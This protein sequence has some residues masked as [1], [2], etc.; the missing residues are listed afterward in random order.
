MIQIDFA[1]RAI[2]EYDAT[3]DLDEMY[4]HASNTADASAAQGSTVADELDAQADALAWAQASAVI[5][6]NPYLDPSRRRPEYVE[7]KSGA[8]GT[9]GDGGDT[10]GGYAGE[11]TRRVGARCNA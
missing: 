8:K 4:S 1:G 11:R 5:A 2:R 3:Q 10:G 9:R 6:Q 7:S